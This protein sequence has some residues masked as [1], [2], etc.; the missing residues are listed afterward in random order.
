MKKRL[1]AIIAVLLSVACLPVAPLGANAMVQPNDWYDVSSEGIV[2]FLGKDIVEEDMLPPLGETMIESYFLQSAMN[3]NPSAKFAVE[4]HAYVVKDYSEEEKQF[5]SEHYMD[6]KSY[7]EILN[8]LHEKSESQ[9]T[10]EEKELAWQIWGETHAYIHTLYEEQESREPEWLKEQGINVVSHDESGMFNYA[11][12]THEQLENFPVSETSGY[13]IFLTTLDSV[14]ET[15]RVN[16]QKISKELKEHIGFGETSIPVSVRYRPYDDSKVEEM[17]QAEVDKALEGI[18]ADEIQEKEVEIRIRARWDI[19]NNL[20]TTQ[21]ESIIS[22]MEI[23]EESMMF[24]S[25]YIPLIICNLSPEQIVQ[26]SNR[27]DIQELSYY[28]DESIPFDAT[29]EDDFVG[30]RVVTMVKTKYSKA[31]ENWTPEYINDALGITDIAYVNPILVDQGTGRRCIFIGL[32]DDT[33]ETALAVAQK[34]DN[35]DWFYSVDLDGMS[36]HTELVKNDE[37]GDIDGSGEVNIVDVLALNQYLL[38]VY[39]PD[40]AGI[41][42]ADVNHD[43]NVDDADSMMLLKSLVGLETLQ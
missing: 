33:K 18:P 34:L 13:K 17:I 30:G 38:G 14:D 43:G 6:G 7:A 28:E 3:E 19:I 12:V 8:T 5:Q 25:K 32:N 26:F 10:K 24:S 36:Y 16:S 20:Y 29:I 31:S 23:P 21:G 42:S 39:E 22:E 9:Y 35:T 41:S 2:Y 27:D 15:A 40:N 11:I 4:I 37:T 1:N